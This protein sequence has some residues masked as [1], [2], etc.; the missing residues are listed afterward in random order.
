MDHAR[1]SRPR[2]RARDPIGNHAGICV[3]ASAKRG[4]SAGRL[5]PFQSV[6]I[7]FDAKH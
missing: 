4:K 1:E 5:R 3:G 6:E 2:L 7:I